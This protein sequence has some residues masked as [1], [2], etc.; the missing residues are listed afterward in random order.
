MLSRCTRFARTRFAAFA[1]ITAACRTALQVL[2]LLRACRVQPLDWGGCPPRAR[3]PSLAKL[4]V[5]SSAC[6][7][8]PK[9]HEFAV[10]TSPTVEGGALLCFF[11]ANFA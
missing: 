5:I 4:S 11:A 9:W 2:S 1:H 10:L 6:P 7:R 8:K 3:P